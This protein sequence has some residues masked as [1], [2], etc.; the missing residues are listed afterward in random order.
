MIKKWLTFGQKVGFFNI[1]WP[2]A[3]EAGGAGGVGGAIFDDFRRFS[4][5][6]D[7]FRQIPAILS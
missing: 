5:I 6:F 3:G 7:D 1:S 2:G 4:T